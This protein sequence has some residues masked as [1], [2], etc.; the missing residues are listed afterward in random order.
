[1]TR[2]K[3]KGMTCQHCV[4]AVTKALS[5]IDGITDVR[6]DLEKGETAYEA[7][8]PVDMAMIRQRIQEAG[9]FPWKN[10]SSSS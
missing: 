9:Y 7:T 5:R 3:I 2:I 10:G 8:K 4:A 6:V 1:M